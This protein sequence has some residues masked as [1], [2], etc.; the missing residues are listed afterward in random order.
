M[1]RIDFSN[2]KPAKRTRT[3]FRTRKAPMWKRA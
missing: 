3:A 2:D 1:I